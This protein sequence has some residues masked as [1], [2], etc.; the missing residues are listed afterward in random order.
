MSGTNKR[1]DLQFGSFACSV[2]GFDDPVQPVQQVL[3]ALQNLLEETPQLADAGIQFDAEAIDR[4]MGEVAR[5]ADL[6]EKNI[7]IVP[8]LIIVHR[9]DSGVD[10]YSDTNEDAF[11]DTNYREADLVAAESDG[12]DPATLEDAGGSEDD[13]GADS[14]FFN[15]FSPGGGFGGKTGTKSASGS[16]SGLF[17]Q[18]ADDTPDQADDD[19]AA[20]RQDDP[21]TAR[22]GKAAK[23]ADETGSGNIGDGDRKNSP[24]RNIFAEALD[25]EPSGSTGD[26]IFADPM[27]TSSE[28]KTGTEIATINF[29]SSARR[30]NW[31][32]DEADGVD[33]LFASTAPEY[34]PLYAPEDAPED[35]PEDTVGEPEPED[36]DPQRGAALFGPSDDQP[37]IEAT[38]EGYTAAGLAKTAEA[39]SVADL[40]VSAAAWM[41]LIQGQTSFSRSDV[42][43]VFETIPGEHLKTLEARVRGFGKAVRNGQLI[44]IEEGVFGLSRAEMERFQRML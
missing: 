38:D 22:F 16:G 26:N 17:T 37:E 18:R 35:T 20:D 33:N 36:G 7:E 39:K 13:G 5:R 3:Q 23:P 21:F 25:T 9:R 14:G 32:A 28:A 24:A 29:F 40:M 2:Q 27:A 41:V 42:V 44:M 8:G 43:E 4:L 30:A 31:G 34:E 15:I 11:D 19:G 1:L 12:A 6:D 10:D